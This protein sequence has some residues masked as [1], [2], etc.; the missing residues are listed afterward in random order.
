VPA[1]ALALANHPLGPGLG[2][3]VR[4]VLLSGDV[5]PRSLVRAIEGRLPFAKVFLHYGQTEFGLGGAVE[6]RHRL[7]PH[8][9]EADIILEILG[10]GGES[11]PAGE[12][13]E[14]G[15]IV[16]T[17][18]SREAM[19]LLRY[20]TG[21]LGAVVPGICPCGS[22]FR[23]LRTF[24]RLADRVAWP[25][26]ET[27]D[28]W[29]ICEALYGL[30]GLTRFRAVSP[31]APGW[32]LRLEVTANGGPDEPTERALAV[33]L[34]HRPWEIAYLD[35]PAEPGSPTGKQVLHRPGAD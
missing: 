24:G 15:E 32:R 11:L 1:Q 20:R 17:S 5:A 13:G 23:R 34:G 14:I 2:K 18:L 22:V 26:G 19:P 8:F 33:L 3:T 4:S 21:D 28:L 25:G 30:P 6:C 27:M 10:P 7:G 29:R 35:S 9:R 16:L 12:I 31:E